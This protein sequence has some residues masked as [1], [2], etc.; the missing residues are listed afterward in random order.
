MIPKNIPCQINN[1]DQVCKY[2]VSK[3]NPLDDTLLYSVSRATDSE[4][5]SAVAAASDA[6]ASWSG[7]SSVQRG[8]ILLNIARKL[9]DDSHQMAEVVAKETGKSFNDALGETKGAIQLAEF[10]A[11]EGMRL[12]G[13]SLSS[14]NA[15]K[16]S[17]TVRK[18]HGVAA[19]IIAANTPIAN[20]AWKVFPALI[21]GN[22][23]VLKASEDAPATSWLFAKICYEAGLPLG[24]LNILQG[25]GEE[26][27]EPLVCH[28]D[29]KVISFTG[30]TRVGKIVNELAASRLKR[31]SLELGGKNPFVVCDDADLDKA[32]HWAVLSSF[33]N[34]GQRCAATSRILI[35]DDVFDKF[36][37]LFIEKTSALKQGNQDGEIGPVIKRSQLDFMLS[38]VNEAKTRGAT[39][40]CGGEPAQRTG[41]FMQPTII[42]L[43]SADDP[44]NNIELF[45][46]ITTICRIPNLTKA[47]Q[48]ANESDYGLTAAIH[49][50]DVNKSMFFAHNVRA[51][52]VNVNAGTYGSEPHYP[53]GGM[54]SSGNGTREPGVEA[55]DIYTSLR[56][57]SLVADEVLV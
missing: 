49:T 33:S 4:V 8:K 25:L 13:R 48:V 44:I 17:L 20:V 45:G 18:P 56:T 55:L 38:Q 21:C 57:I 30:S 40:V 53:F 51:G 19:L 28:P 9:E 36:K 35:F 27:G 15:H 46:P 47:I 22:T 31:I 52:A 11:G 32:V 39:V 37:R 24:V 26:C 7:M 3:M 16:T 42:E 5:N 14:G 29:V 12:Y 43:Q 41:Y 54:G 10:F 2:T 1:K 6:F 34:A 50:T 23:A